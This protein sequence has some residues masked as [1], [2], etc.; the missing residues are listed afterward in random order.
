MNLEWLHNKQRKKILIFCNGWGMDSAPF[1][2]IESSD[3]DVLNLYDFDNILVEDHNWDFLDNYSER[4]LLSWSMGVW[5]GQRLFCA[6]PTIFSRKIAVNGT[7]CP[8]DRRYGI[9]RDLFTGTMEAW[10]ELS[11][12]KFYR[13]ACGS[14]SVS[15][16][17]LD[18]QPGRTLK[19]QQDELGYYLN[20]A[21]CIDQRESIYTEIVIADKDRIVPTANQVEYWGCSNV[22]M[23]NGSHFL[24]YTWKSWDDMLSELNSHSR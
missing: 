22:A 7:L 13:R 21:D 14:K 1:R 11:R 17:F 4:I 20:H 10:S 18:C 15:S 19:E 3:Y 23:I 9:P 5:A 8:V 6:D 24:F 16:I 12:E 2:A